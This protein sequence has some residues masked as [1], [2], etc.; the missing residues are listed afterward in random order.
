MPKKF[1]NKRFWCWK[2]RVLHFR[3]LPAEINDC[4]ELF[5]PNFGHACVLIQVQGLVFP[6]K[7]GWTPPKKEKRPLRRNGAAQR[8]QRHPLGCLSNCWCFSIL[9]IRDMSGIGEILSTMRWFLEHC[10][11]SSTDNTNPYWTT[12]PKE[13]HQLPCYNKHFKEKTKRITFNPLW[14][15]G[16]TVG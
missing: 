3:F 11:K 13:S 1:W 6:M 9:E 12:F 8:A 16:L 2:V 5:T 15:S 10:L 4:R 14:A 7:G